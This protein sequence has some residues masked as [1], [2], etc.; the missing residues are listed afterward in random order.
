MFT[1]IYCSPYAV[2][3]KSS[4]FELQIG[5]LCFILNIVETYINKLSYSQD[6]RHFHQNKQIN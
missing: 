4:I 6:D 2:L 3:K 5:I 1:K